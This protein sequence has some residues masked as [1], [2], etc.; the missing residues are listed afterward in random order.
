MYSGVL[1]FL[2]LVLLKLISISAQGIKI[3]EGQYCHSWNC[4]KVEHPGSVLFSYIT[5]M[6]SIKVL[7]ILCKFHLNL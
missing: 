4:W 5:F 6:R 1:F 7:H 2:T 3:T